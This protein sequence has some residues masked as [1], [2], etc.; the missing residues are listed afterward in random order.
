MYPQT[1]I[2]FFSTKSNIFSLN[3]ENWSIL[4]ESNKFIF[5][6]RIFFSLLCQKGLKRKYNEPILVTFPHIFFL[7]QFLRIIFQLFFLCHG[8]KRGTSNVIWRKRNINIRRAKQLVSRSCCCCY[9]DFLH[10]NKRTNW[11]IL[12]WISSSKLCTNNDY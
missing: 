5:R 2:I 3:M 1:K 4:V 9:N 11:S 6:L 8:M 10:F 7:S 12:S